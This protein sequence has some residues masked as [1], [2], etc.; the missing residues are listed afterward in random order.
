MSNE[1]YVLKYPNGKFVAIDKISGGYPYETSILGC[2]RFPTKALA[3]DYSSKFSDL[4]FSLEIITSR[5]V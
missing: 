5:K 1:A 3:E 4:N 2:S